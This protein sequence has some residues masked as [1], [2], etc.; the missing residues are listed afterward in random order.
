[1]ALLASTAL[2]AVGVVVPDSTPSSKDSSILSVDP[3]GPYFGREGEPVELL[4]TATSP[5]ASNVEYRWDVNG[6]G[7]WDSNWSPSGSFTY[8][9][10]DD[11][12]GQACVQGRAAGGSASI[13]R[14]TGPFE[15]FSIVRR[16]ALVGQSFVANRS[17]VTRLRFNVAINVETPEFPLVVTLNRTLNGTAL[18][19]WVIPPDELPSRQLH[20]VEVEADLNLEVGKRYFVVFQTE[21]H[22]GTYEVHDALD[23][24]AA[25]SLFT[26]GGFADWYEVTEYDVLMEIAG[27]GDALESSCAPIHIGNVPPVVA[28]DPTLPLEVNEGS[29]ILLAATIEDPGSDDLTLRWSGNCQGWVD[30]VYPNDPTKFPDPYPSP[31]IHPLNVTDTQTVVCGDDG[32][33]A[34]SLIVTDDDGGLTSMNGTFTVSNLPPSLE[35]APPAQFTVDEGTNVSLTATA[36]DHGS[37]DLTF[38]WAWQY[39][40]TDTHVH[41]N[42]GVGPDPSH[43]PNGTFPLTAADSSSFTYGDDGNHTVILTVTD[44]DGGSLTY[45]TTITGKNVP[46]TVEAGPD[47]SMDEG[48]T[49]SF[50]FAFSDPGFDQPD[51]GTWEDFTASVD[52]GDGTSGS[53]AVS[54]VPGGPGVPTTGTVP[55]SHIYA[56]NGNYTVT[57][58]VCDDDGGC[59]SDSLVVGVGNVPPTVDPVP[60]QTVDE[61]SGLDLMSSFSDPGFDFTPAGTVEDFNAS[62]AWGDTTSDSPPVDETPGSAGVPTTGTVDASHIYADDGHYRTDVVVCDDDGGCGSTSF[63]V[64]VNNVPPTAEAGADRTTDEGSLVSFTFS[65]SDPGF[66]FPAAGTWEDFTAKVTWGDGTMETLAV[67]EV[68]GSPGD[69]TTGTMSAVH[70]YADNGLYTVTVTV[71]DDDGGCGSDTLVV[72]VLNVP[73][74]VHAGPD[75]GTDEGSLASFNFTF[76]DPGFDFPPAGAWENFT[77]TVDWG[78]GTGGS[79][80]V[81]EV[82]GSPGVPTTGTV[83]A[84]HVY[85]DNGE[86]RVTI[87]V[88]DD[89]GGCGSDALTVTVANVPPT[90][91]AGEDRVVDEA[92]PLALEFRFTDPGFDFPPAGTVEDFTTVVDW[93]YGPAEDVPVN[94]TPGAPGVPTRGGISVM[95]VYG[96]NGLFRVTVTVCDDDGGC[97]SDVMNVTVNNVA[98]VIDDVQAYVVANVTLRVAGEKWHDVRMDL[99]WNGNVTATARVVREPGSPDEQT[100]TISGGRIQLLGDTRIVLTYTPDDDPVNGQPNGANPAWV[101]L[102]FPDGSEVVF[103]QT[104][105]VHHPDTWTWTLDDFRPYLAGQEVTFNATAHD[106]GSDDL[107]FT[108]SFGDGTPEM[109]TIYYNDGIGP[110]PFP[111]PEV[112]PITATDIATHAYAAP[113]AYTV[114]LTVTD[115]DGGVVRAT[116]AMTVG[117]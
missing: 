49:I 6:D 69:P 11:Y 62:V 7:T 2:V 116:F 114:S 78:D 12:E 79:L 80:S 96:D 51:A 67:Y 95:H 58:S 84:S 38:T 98:P 1:M 66:D 72:T 74:T 102:T 16:G 39:G 89:D 46:P 36:R 101:I 91:E 61:G 70:V 8:T 43:S 77:A 71:C 55:A 17:E 97:G 34:W 30:R 106:V 50:L 27:P 81:I 4:A 54:E 115:D 13:Y 107:R 18:A 26:K 83:P 82:P 24:Y 103:H 108:W 14:V 45:A 48:S 65:F 93:G 35:V 15:A 44:D 85:A 60:D 57:V 37:D 5:N 109:S 52:W 64:T 23:Q 112:N 53:P 90:V 99:G 87:T 110:D 21:D 25:G 41:Y 104:F 73:P 76:S 10:G 111:S 9:F 100:A 68:P 3:G 22:V 113:G 31:D 29:A 88:C 94:E 47:A 33:F 117:A 42:D 63:Y 75:S 92:V 32:V 59:G 56:D 20:W 86:Y 19:T 105:N 40:P 28:L